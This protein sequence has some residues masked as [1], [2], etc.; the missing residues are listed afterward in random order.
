MIAAHAR[1]LA[2]IAQVSFVRHEPVIRAVL[3]LPDGE[4]VACGMSPGAPDRS[5]DAP[6]RRTQS[7][8][9]CSMSCAGCG[10]CA[11]SVERRIGSFFADHRS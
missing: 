3:G 4:T 11:E 9:R 5:S 2:T 7:S 8:P 6:Q 10:P 1:G